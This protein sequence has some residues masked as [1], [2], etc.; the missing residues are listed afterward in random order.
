MECPGCQNLYEAGPLSCPSCGFDN[1][2]AYHQAQ[3]STEEKSVPR[4][5]GESIKQ[6]L[7]RIMAVLLVLGGVVYLMEKVDWTGPQAYGGMF[8]LLAMLSIVVVYVLYAPSFG[9]TKRGVVRKKKKP[10]GQ[11]TMIFR[12]LNLP[13]AEHLRTFLEGEGIPAFIYNR[14]ATTLEPFDAFAGIRVMVPT[15]R[16]AE[17]KELMIAFGFDTEDIEEY[18]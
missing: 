15:D 8:I 13:R 3:A 7:G 10:S 17:V 11:F 18:E 4:L 5:L 16:L 9:P 2:A 12:T 1:Q 6:V 14:N